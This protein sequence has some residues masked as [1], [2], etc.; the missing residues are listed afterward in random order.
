MKIFNTGDED[1]KEQQSSHPSQGRH[2][3]GRGAESDLT[4]KKCLDDTEYLLNTSNINI[5]QSVH[6]SMDM[7]ENNIQNN[8]GRAPGA[9]NAAQAVGSGLAAQKGLVGARGAAT[10]SHHQNQLIAAPGNMANNLIDQ[11]YNWLM[12]NNVIN[13]QQE[14][15]NSKSRE[16]TDTQGINSSVGKSLKVVSGKQLSSHLSHHSQVQTSHGNEAEDQVESQYGQTA[17]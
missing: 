3:E 11:Q 12:Q 15:E 10:G 17:V 13:E 9:A 1:A 2:G 16:D 4:G 6:M 14:Y 7:K 5:A 8:I